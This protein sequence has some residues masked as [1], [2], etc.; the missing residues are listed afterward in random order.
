MACEYRISSKYGTRIDPIT[1]EE[2]KHKG[3]DIVGVHH[4]EIL[5][6]AKGEVTYSGVM[7]TYGNCIEIKHIVKGEEIYSFYAH[8]SRRDV[9]VGDKVE[10]GEVIGLEGGDQ[11]TDPNPGNT[12]G[13]HLHF[14][15][16]N[17]TGSGND[18]DPS[19]Y[20]EF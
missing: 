18:V 14:E 3:I 1:K 8:L 13:H 2:K 16:R 5:S 6:V 17:K 12:T 7:G 10:Q 20:I 19:K 15:I 4:T 9:K 11:K